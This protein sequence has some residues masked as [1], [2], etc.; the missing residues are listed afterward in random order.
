M[1]DR[2]GTHADILLNESVIGRIAETVESMLL[3][4]PSAGIILSGKK[5]SDINGEFVCITGISDSDPV[6]L[7]VGSEEGGTEPSETDIALFKRFFERGILMKVDV[8]AKEF[9]FYKIDDTVE[10]ASALFTE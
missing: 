1:A 7:C 6:A 2:L 4:K 3:E 10:D 9:A 5:E 8:Y